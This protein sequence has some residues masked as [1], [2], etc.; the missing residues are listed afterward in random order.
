MV[1]IGLIQWFL[2]FYRSK[3][4]KTFVQN[5][6]TLLGWQNKQTAKSYAYVTAPLTNQAIP[7]EY[8]YE[9]LRG[10]HSGPKKI[11]REKL[12]TK[13]TTAV[14]SFSLFYFL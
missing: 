8:L 12:L 4:P 3:A 7:L 9:T 14:S 2:T 6:W 1:N 13:P 10:E 5:L 11:L